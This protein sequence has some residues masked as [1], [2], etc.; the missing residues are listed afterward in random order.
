MQPNLYGAP[1]P[2]TFFESRAVVPFCQLQ[3]A[4]RAGVSASLGISLPSA[5]F[6]EL[7][8]VYQTVERREP[9][10]GE[11]RLFSELHR[12]TARAAAR[13]AV[14]TLDTDSAALAE[15]WADL[16]ERRR[17]MEGGITTP[18]ILTDV[19]GVVG[20]Q[21][22]R[23]GEQPA[24]P[25]FRVLADGG[26]ATAVAAQAVGYE[27]IL[28]FPAGEVPRLLC[29]LTETDTRSM[30]KNAPRA[31]DLILLLHGLPATAAAQLS[32][33]YIDPRTGETRPNLIPLEGRP[34]PL[35]LTALGCGVEICAE[36]LLP[37]LSDGVAAA[38]THYG[39]VGDHILRI[40][41]E[42]LAR[43]QELYRTLPEAG[44]FSVIGQTIGAER[45]TILYNGMRLVGC[46]FSTLR[47]A[48]APGLYSFRADTAVTVAPPAVAASEAVLLTG[49][50]WESHAEITLGAGD[51]YRQ[52]LAAAEVVRDSLRA[53]GVGQQI[54][55]S[56]VLTGIPLGQDDHPT[57]GDALA[58]L[59]GVYRASAEH[60][61]PCPDPCLREAV[62]EGEPCRLSVCGFAPQE[63]GA[64]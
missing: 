21:L 29:R 58:A 13:T 54:S 3:P 9:T 45:L 22:C 55:L 17:R 18:C 53:A 11:L 32:R 27:S 34:L 50:V 48:V 16:T 38:L 14:G 36:T 31:G 57:A 41:R 24:R 64:E 47:T 26:N 33:P 59:C 46:G 43:V 19:P 44:S 40:H 30:K 12:L 7:Q 20:E 25:R 37:G 6:A 39:T 35:L 56:V 28:S 51:G 61:L 63:V 4:A 60:R 52:G 62:V 10:V 49:G 5:V 42:E 15:T 2:M 8:A 23:S 1:A